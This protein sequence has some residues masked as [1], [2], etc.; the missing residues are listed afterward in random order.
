MGADYSFEVKNIEIWVPA[1]F[2]H[3]NSSVATVT[4]KCQI[5]AQKTMQELSSFFD[6]YLFVHIKIRKISWFVVSELI[7]GSCEQDMWSEK[8]YC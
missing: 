7:S 5:E 2:K 1:F 6:K 4:S 8:F 3:D